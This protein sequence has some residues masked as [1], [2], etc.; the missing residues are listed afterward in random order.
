MS[1]DASSDT[2][3][4]SEA[5]DELLIQA[6][7]IQVQDLTKDNEKLRTQVGA[8]AARLEALKLMLNSNILNNIFPYL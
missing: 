5:T 1:S 3:I 4:M 8:L 7:E 2:R 6:L